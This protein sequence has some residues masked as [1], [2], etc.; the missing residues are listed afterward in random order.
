MKNIPKQKKPKI[1]RSKALSDVD[2]MDI[3]NIP[4]YQTIPF[5][6]FINITKNSDVDFTNY[7]I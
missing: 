6:N 5:N 7:I 4:N 2:N 1:T 3:S